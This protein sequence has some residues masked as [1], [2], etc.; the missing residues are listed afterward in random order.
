MS[1]W[2][3]QTMELDTTGVHAP[4]HLHIAAHQMAGGGDRGKN[5]R[6]Y[7]IAVWVTG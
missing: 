1:H 5:R 4:Q 3:L 6:P 2:D 7:F